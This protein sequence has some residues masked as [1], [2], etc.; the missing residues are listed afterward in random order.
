MCFTPDGKLAAASINLLATQTL[1]N[2]L[3]K[4]Q[5]GKTL[6]ARVLASPLR[7][8]SRAPAVSH[9]TSSHC[10]LVSPSP[11]PPPPLPSLL[12]PPPPLPPSS[13]ASVVG[14]SPRG[15]VTATTVANWGSSPSST[16]QPIRP[17]TPLMATSVS[18]SV[19]N[20][21]TVLAGTAVSSTPTNSSQLDSE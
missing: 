21:L 9:N 14:G 6:A 5:P 11:P 12:P 18:Q 4:T 10:L 7:P 16:P 1:I 2:A 20:P 3:S 8:Q 13:T 17:L 19:D 15:I